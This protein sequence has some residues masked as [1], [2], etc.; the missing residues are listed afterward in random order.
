MKITG[1][2]N[3]WLVARCGVMLALATSGCSTLIATSGISNV[4]EIYQLETRAEVREAFGE[5]DETGTCPDGRPVEHRM[6][7]QKVREVW[8]DILESF[9][10]PRDPLG[11]LVAYLD[12]LVLSPAI[13]VFATPV[14]VYRSEQAK[15]HYAFVYGSDDR[16]VYRYNADASSPQRFEEAVLPLTNSLPGQ[17]EKGGR[18]SWGGC[19][20]TF[21]AEVQQRAA[22]VAH[23]LTWEYEE[24]L[25]LLQA[26]A[27]EVDAGRLA[28]DE[29]L[30]E[31]R[32][33]LRSTPWSCFRP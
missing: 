13:D 21:G 4:A 17:L 23:P 14:Q 26:L 18:P 5:A 16:V 24:T 1:G 28:P 7:R 10:N 29:T 22:C 27:A 19:L 3:R 25:Y 6:I 8:A 20:I 32:W 9:F 30:A 2:V 11:S 12:L 15:L 31:L 33:C